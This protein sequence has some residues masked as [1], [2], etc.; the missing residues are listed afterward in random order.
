VRERL[1]DEVGARSALDA[2]RELLADSEDRAAE[3]YLAA[4]APLS[5]CKDGNS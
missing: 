2:A 5:E 4:K 3:R 1:D